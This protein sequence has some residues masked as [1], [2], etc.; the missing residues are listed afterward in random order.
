MDGMGSGPEWL[1]GLSWLFLAS[2]VIS[3]GVILRD[4]HRLGNRQPRRMMEIVW[5]LSGL[6]LG[7]IAVLIYRKY[8]QTTHGCPRARAVRC[9]MPCAVACGMAHV[10]GV[11][12]VVLGGITL[13][14]EDMGAMMVI[15]LVLAVAMIFALEAW[16]LSRRGDRGLTRTAMRRA[17]VI[18]LVAAVAFDAGMLGWM[19]VLH[20]F[21][22]MPSAGDIRFTFLMQIGLIVGLITAYPAMRKLSSGHNK[23]A[24]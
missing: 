20:M 2:A 8:G 3:A 4:I 14:G 5:P 13:G 7:P 17:A 6:C 15:V 9:S 18:A 12:I 11:P 10:V 1:I 24:W 23:T 16:A 22:T 19:M 21:E